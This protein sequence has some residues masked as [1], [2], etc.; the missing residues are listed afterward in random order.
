MQLQTIPINKNWHFKQTTPLNASCASTWL[1]VSQF[2]TVAHLDLL[3]HNLIPDPYIDTNEL[4]CLWVNDA[5]FSYRT[6]LPP[7]P[8]LTSP[9]QKIV[10]VFDGLDTIVSV[11][12][13]EKLILESN[14]MHISHRVDVTSLLSSSSSSEN[15]LELK[16]T[17]APAY[18]KREM[19]RIGYKGN[20]TD[21]HFG[22]PERLFV[23]KA[24]FH[25]GWDWG[26]AVNTCGPWKGVRMEVF[27]QR[28][29]GLVVR[30][31]VEESLESVMVSVKGKVE[32]GAEKVVLVVTDPEGEVVGRETVGVNAE[33]AFEG[34]VKVEKP[35]L[36]WPFGYGEQPLYTVKAEIEGSHLVERRVG[37]R[38]LKLLQHGLEG[39]EGTSFT[40]EVNG[41]RIFCG[42]SCWIPGDFMLPRMTEE[43]YRDWLT[44]AKEGNQVMIR[45]WGGGIVESDDFYN[46]C[47]EL[48]ILVWQDFLFACGDYPASDDFCELVK[49][50][51]EQQVIRVGHHAS[52]AIWAG[53]NE[54][55]MLAERWGWEYDPKDQE[56]PWDHTNFPARKIYERILPEVCERLAG[57]VPYWRSSPYG[58]E[59][60]NDLRVGDT[61]IWDVWHG[62][63][64]P[65]QDYKAYTSRFISE[66]GFESA[67]SLRTLHTAITSPS[68]RHWQ[69]LTFD[70]H[71]K[72]PGHQ[73][74]YGMYSGE[75][76][77]F[78][79]NPLSDFVYCTQFL[80]AE[81]MKYAYNHWRREFRG[82]GKEFCSGILVWQLNDVWPGTSWAL[83][84]VRGDR[85]AS[86]YITKRALVRVGVGMERVVTGSV[87]Y[88][89]TSYP[90]PK[91]KL[92]VWAV[93]GFLGKLDCKLRLKAF[94]IETG[95]EVELGERERDVVLEGNQTT[96]LL[97]VELG[98]EAEKMVV[99]AY[100]DDSKTGER[101]ARWVD[102]P[103]PL[104]FVHFS[105][106]PNVQAKVV[107]QE[108]V[109]SADA[110]IKGVMLSVPISEGGDDARWDDNFVD[111]VPGEEVRIGVKGLE[112]RKVETRWLCDW[113]NEKGFEL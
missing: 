66:F 63:M 47:D 110:P 83:V 69:S 81:A 29:G 84:D 60:S 111:L 95:K 7:I 64:S 112:A 46:C 55:Y 57:D 35:R 26:P 39:E 37:V 15:V 42:G 93:N 45:V 41:V 8:S 13:N 53:N 49:K 44:L 22:G 50:E 20:G 23:R 27:E 89:V 19:K 98:K 30:Q 85:K 102:W 87:P 86:F 67:P 113:E 38:K 59:T 52:L 74:R 80:Q 10:L 97:E 68:E 106:N 9:A 92:A 11:Y 17:N 91:R 33:G 5:D 6:T 62:K 76:F 79:F 103:E 1:P 43:R 73:R 88:M 61:H 101:L 58:G 4:S 90:A 3:H 12:L 108:V 56:G 2:P 94:E 40:F 48:G 51:A 34:E 31:K 100:L 36:W 99:V 25:W 109:L 104:K 32:G 107:G 65:F 82:P 28:V 16:F 21:V 24:Q 105:K 75:N 54:D 18:A 14:N 71:D 70:A 72:G 77:R 96:E 78:R